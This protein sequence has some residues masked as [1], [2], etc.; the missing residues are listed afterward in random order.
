M[1]I[2]QDWHGVPE[3]AR[4]ATVALGNFDGVHLG[5]AAVLRAAHGAR[6]DLPLAALTF[7]PHPREHFRPDDPPFRLTVLAAKAEAL[8]ALGARTVFAIPFGEKLAAMSAESFVEEVLHQGIGAKHLACGADFAF[9]HRRGGDVAFLAREAEKRGIGL[10]VVPAVTDAAGPVSSTRIRRVLQD[11]YPDLAAAMLGRDWELR[12]EVFHGDKLGRELG[13]PTANILLGRQLEPARGV[14]AVT[15]RLADG[16]LVPGVA[17]VGRRPTLGGDPVTRL[18]VHLFDFSGD[19]YGQEIGVRIRA[20][21]RA[22]AK[23]DGLQA[24]QDA[25]AADAR[26][27][28]R[29]L[30]IS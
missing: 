13:W 16:R 7:E 9:G 4:G 12:G 2:I 3:A 19:L 18:E 20:F 14:Y 5:H 1:T 24:L 27:A 21:L 22:D 28:R 26:N 17:N 10:T 23:F 25:I 15:V 11:G 8:G 30:G 29:V 6:P